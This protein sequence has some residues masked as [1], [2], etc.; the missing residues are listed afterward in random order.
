[1]R[2]KQ[3]ER[4]LEL[5]QIELGQAERDQNQDRVLQLFQEKAALKRR[6]LA[7]AATPAES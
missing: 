3:I 2:Q 4:R 6:K 7:I 5:I 1:L